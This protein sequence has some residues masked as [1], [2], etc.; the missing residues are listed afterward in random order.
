MA[1]DARRGRAARQGRA[2]RGRRS[3]TSR[4]AAHASPERSARLGELRRGRRGVREGV[5]VHHARIEGLDSARQLAL[6]RAPARA[7]IRVLAHC[8]DEAMTAAAE[9]EL[10]GALRDDSASCRCGARRRPSSSPPP[11]RAARAHHRRPRDDRPREPARGRRARRARAGERRAP[12]R[13]DLPAVPAARRGGGR[14]P[15]ADAQVH[16]ARA[17]GT[18][19]RGAVGAAGVRAR[20]TCC[21]ATMR[22]RRWPR[23]TRA[24]SGSARSACPASTRPSR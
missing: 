21:R 9:R 3:S 12:G 24:T 8:E 15:R 7:G 11:P 22:P 19:R 2:P 23:S 6:L 5:H 1:R 20:S 17:P 4:S 14:P 18:R 16:A 13:R 10:R